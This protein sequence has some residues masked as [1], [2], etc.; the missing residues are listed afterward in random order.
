MNPVVSV[1]I[2]FHYCKQLCNFAE[3]KELNI[4]FY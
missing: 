1:H 3:E 4:A 2:F